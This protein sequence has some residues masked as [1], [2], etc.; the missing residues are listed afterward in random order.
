M[1]HEEGQ[2]RAV[3]SRTGS[4]FSTFWENTSKI[5]SGEA[6]SGGRCSPG[7]LPRGDRRDDRERRQRGGVPCARKLI[8]SLVR[9]KNF[10]ATHRWI[11][12]KYAGTWNE[13]A[14]IRFGHHRLPLCRPACSCPRSRTTGNLKD[15]ALSMRSAAWW[16]SACFQATSIPRALEGGLCRASREREGVLRGQALVGL[17]PS[18][19][20]L[21]QCRGVS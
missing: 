12:N 14:R 15:A 20:G 10:L 4:P 2:R 17:Y 16:R 1:G 3:S 11:G 18:R 9:R 8:S 6:I 5:P 19:S 13:G 21:R 7:S